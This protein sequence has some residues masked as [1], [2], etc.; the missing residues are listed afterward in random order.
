MINWSEVRKQFPV[1]ERVAYLNSAAAGPL[2]RDVAAAG[3]EY[4]SQMMVEGD[5][6]W[7]E[8]LAKRED[9]RRRVAAFINAEPDEIGL[10]TNTSS[11]M[12]VIVDAVSYT[13]LRAHETPE[14]LVC[15]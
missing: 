3:S 10:T 7:D 8:W 12:S 9:V 13:H 4:Y 15:R 6:R 1:T 11:G 5:K 14:H 2:T